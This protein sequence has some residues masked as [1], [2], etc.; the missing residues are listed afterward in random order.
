VGEVKKKKNKKEE[1]CDKQQVE[2]SRCRNRVRV[3]A[4][5]VSWQ[6][7]EL[8]QLM[9]GDGSTGKG[10]GTTAAA[11][12]TG[13]GGGEGLGAARAGGGGGGGG[14]GMGA[15]TSEKQQL[16]Q[17]LKAAAAPYREALH[18]LTKAKEEVGGFASR[19]GFVEQLLSNV[20]GHLDLLSQLE[21]PC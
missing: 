21:P 7:G 2:E 17:V 11:A 6:G 9:S 16:Q 12:A 1:K 8:T 13:G 10:L 19:G 15:S 18:A 20:K 3:T 5:G 14:A 4:G